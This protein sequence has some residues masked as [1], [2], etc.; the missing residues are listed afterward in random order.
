MN[1]ERRAHKHASVSLGSVFGRRVSTKT[2]TTPK[3]TKDV[4]FSAVPLA[5]EPENRKLSIHTMDYFI[6]EQGRLKIF[7]LEEK[8]I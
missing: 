3:S 1:I 5:R 8:L 2:P 4:T 6:D 7:I